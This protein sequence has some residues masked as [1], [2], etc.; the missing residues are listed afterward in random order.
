[1][2]RFIAELKARGVLK[3]ATV[4]LALCW[5]IL[6][7]GNTVFDV[8]ELPQGALRAVMV[9]LAVGFPLV[10]FASWRWHFA[11]DKVHG[12]ADGPPYVAIVVG[13]VALFAIAIAIAVH[14]IGG[15]RATDAAGSGPTAGGPAFHPP[16]HSVAVLPF[17]NLSGDAREDYFSDGLSDELLQALAQID[18]LKVAARTSSFSFKGT[19]ADVET[20]ARKLNVGAVLDGSVR[21]TE[22]HVRVSAELVDAST[23]FNL[24]AA[25]YDRQFRDVVAVQTEIAEAVASALEV[26][27]LADSGK[28][29]APGGTLDPKALDA[30]L[31]GKAGERV[32]DEQNLRAAL[33]DLDTA[34]AL[35]PQY[36]NAHALRA[37]VMSQLANMYVSD[38]AERKRL[39]DEALAEGRKA[40][41]LAPNS[42]MAYRKYGRVLS[43]TTDYRATDAAYRR[44]LELDSGSSEA[45]VGYAS[46]A[47]QLGRADALASIQRALALD[48]LNPS[49]LANLGVVQYYSRQFDAARHS[50]QEA[51]LRFDNEVTVDWAA[52]NELASGHP[53]AALPYCER[54]L[55]SWSNQLCLAI[56]YAALG[57][58]Q[59]AAAMQKKLQGAMGEAGAFQYAEIFAQWG[60]TAEA[61]RWL[62]KAVELE[63][64]GLLSIKVDPLLDP[65]RGNRRFQ[66]IVAG[67]DLPS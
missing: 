56:A 4:Y 10:L 22:D 15:Q 27:L 9:L 66:G 57:R 64:P 46:F 49:V 19:N 29:L 17:D 52:V 45:L 39:T 1:M 6:E 11:A 53:S 8:F 25:R 62:E 13:A 40:I 24:W 61:L 31:K 42:G 14:F 65:V 34:I 23:G 50:F 18:A 41:D 54:D 2:R 44:S 47:V 51:M 60:D 7:V 32:Q 43:A 63:D 26:R 28:P 37:D 20:I 55:A 58:K 3:V 35:D 33:L 36:S 59:E 38:P 21:K 30:Y 12:H 16:A 5:L 48:P 67:L